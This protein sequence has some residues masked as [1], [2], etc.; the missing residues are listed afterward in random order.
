MPTTISE[1]RDTPNETDTSASLPEQDELTLL[2]VDEVAALLKVSKS[3]VYEHTRRNGT[4]GSGLPFLK[5][6]KYVRFTPQQVREFLA[7]RTRRT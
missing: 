2:T 3:W 6:G 1:P 4:R 5:I 7:A